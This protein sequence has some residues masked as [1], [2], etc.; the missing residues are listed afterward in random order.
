MPWQLPQLGHP[1]PFLY[2]VRYSCALVL[3]TQMT[4][5]THLFSRNPL[6]HSHQL[7]PVSATHYGGRVG[8]NEVREVP[9]PWM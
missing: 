4:V 8:W 6:Q 9:L 1:P 5:A 7:S 2:K 3:T